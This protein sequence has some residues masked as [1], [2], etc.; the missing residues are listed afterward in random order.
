MNV[1]RLAVSSNTDAA[2]LVSAVNLSTISLLVMI[3]VRILTTNAT[4]AASTAAAEV[5][6]SR[7]LMVF[8]MYSGLHTRLASSYSLITLALILDDI[9]SMPN[10]PVAVLVAVSAPVDAFI[11]FLSSPNRG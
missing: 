3:K 6:G 9:V 8:T 11:V 1:S 2:P 10:I 5:P 7:G 4:S